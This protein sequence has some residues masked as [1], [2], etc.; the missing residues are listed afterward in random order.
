MRNEVLIPKS[1]LLIEDDKDDQD[2]FKEAVSD[3]DNVFLCKISTNGE[4]AL[5][6][7]K[8][9]IIMPDLIF[10][11]INMP[12]LNGIECLLGILANQRTKSIPVVFLTS[13]TRNLESV[14]TLG[15]KA[16]IRKQ[17]DVKRLHSHLKRV[18]D[19]FLFSDSST[20]SQTFM[21]LL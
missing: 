3:I 7:L 16:F 17:A 9:A 20:A 10:A 5:C 2:F 15:A 12:I 21:T 1:V 18:I 4:E 19:F 11:D 13:D 8:E 6:Y 14:H